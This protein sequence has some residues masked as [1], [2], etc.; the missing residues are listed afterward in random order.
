M[1]LKTR[2][3]VAGKESRDENLLPGEPLQHLL[4]DEETTGLLQIGGVLCEKSI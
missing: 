3:E 4:E 1:V 2:H